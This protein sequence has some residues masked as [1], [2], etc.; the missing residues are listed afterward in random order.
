MAL[1]SAIAGPIATLLLGAW[2]GHMLTAQRE[3]NSARRERAVEC[4]TSAY[5]D[6]T[7]PRA[8]KIDELRRILNELILFG[9]SDVVRASIDMRKA[10]DEGGRDFVLSRLSARLRLN[11][12]D[13]LGLPNESNL[14]A[15][16]LRVNFKNDS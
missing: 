10:L 14:W 2:V 6:L 16:A 7:N 1:V 15:P 11:V 13:E 5:R 12:R 9:N 3:R 8:I 4:L